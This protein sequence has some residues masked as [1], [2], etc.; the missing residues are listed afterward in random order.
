M[1]VT[2]A[3]DRAARKTLCARARAPCRGGSKGC[4]AGGMRSD[5]RAIL[6]PTA[7]AGAWFDRVSAPDLMAFRKRRAVG[8]GA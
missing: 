7:G 1:T 8:R 5:V 6:R 2:Q 3:M 4:E